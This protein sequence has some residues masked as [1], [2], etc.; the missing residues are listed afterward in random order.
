MSD[1]F[2]PYRDALQRGVP[3]QLARARHY[4]TPDA[5]DQLEEAF[6]FHWRYALQ[7]L[8][9]GIK[10]LA[11]GRCLACNNRHWRTLERKRLFCGYGYRYTLRM[12]LRTWWYAGKHGED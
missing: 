2:D 9:F 4:I 6:I 8:H 10:Q 11:T 12:G 5:W 3:R 1:A 7:V